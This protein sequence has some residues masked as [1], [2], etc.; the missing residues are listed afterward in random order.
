MS[1]SEVGIVELAILPFEIKIIFSPWVESHYIKALGK[2]RSWILPAQLVASALA[3]LI[4]LNVDYILENKAVYT[5]TALTTLMM[6]CL[7]L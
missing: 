5:L 6:T 2:R 3:L 4:G 1:Y 7:A